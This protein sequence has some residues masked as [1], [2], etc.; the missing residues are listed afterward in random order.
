LEPASLSTC[1][2]NRF[3]FGKAVTLPGSYFARDNVGLRA[4][5]EIWL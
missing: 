5:R 2:E 3:F 1:P 4:L